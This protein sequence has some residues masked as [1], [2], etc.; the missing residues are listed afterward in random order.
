MDFV[1]VLNFLVLFGALQ[2][3]L[4]LVALGRI[5]SRD[6]TANRILSLLVGCISIILVCRL[7]YGPLFYRQPKLAMIPD[8][9]VFLFGPLVYYIATILFFLW[10]LKSGLAIKQALTRR[11]SAK[12]T[13]PP[14]NFSRRFSCQLL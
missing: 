14:A 1:S 8:I 3:V 4:I 9:I 5:G 12:P 6:H 10:P 2:G 11:L 13:K 7:S